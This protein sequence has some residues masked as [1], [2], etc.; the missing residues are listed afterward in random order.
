MNVSVCMYVYVCVLFN[1][2]TLVNQL[3]VV[4]QNKIKSISHTEEEVLVG[5]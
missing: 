5:Q 1:L 2:A 4:L 3:Y